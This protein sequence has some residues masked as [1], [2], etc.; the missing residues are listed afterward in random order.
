MIETPER[1]NATGTDRADAAAK[2]V[3]LDDHR[4]P[5]P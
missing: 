4:Y 5:L 1:A 2:A 3:A